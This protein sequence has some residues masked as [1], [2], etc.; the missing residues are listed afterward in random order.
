MITNII[1]SFFNLIQLTQIETLN[2]G[3]NQS[4]F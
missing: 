1:Q 3:I 2:F 4:I